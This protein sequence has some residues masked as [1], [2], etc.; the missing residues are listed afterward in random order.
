M[1]RDGYSFAGAGG[2]EAYADY[3]MGFKQ[4]IQYSDKTRQQMEHNRAEQE[5]SEKMLQRVNTAKQV[6]FGTG[7]AQKNFETA[8]KVARNETTKYFNKSAV[9]DRAFYLKYG[10]YLRRTGNILTGADAMLSVA[11]YYYSD[12]RSWGD[13]TKLGVNLGIAGIGLVRHPAAQLTSVGLGIAETAGAFDGLYKYMDATEKSGVLIVPG[14]Y[15]PMPFI[16]KIK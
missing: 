1:W 12:D 11:E 3:D 15:S 4:F 10:K 5:F 16:F 14:I 2:G 8:V 9:Y 7:L 6:T 13:K